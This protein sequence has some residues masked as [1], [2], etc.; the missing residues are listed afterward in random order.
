MNPQPGIHGILFLFF[1]K[2]VS[3]EERFLRASS[4]SSEHPGTRE[5][6]AAP[7]SAARRSGT[8]QTDTRG[9]QTASAPAQTPAAFQLLLFHLLYHSVLELYH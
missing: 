8:G 5:G 1:F 3:L 7:P 2:M 6:F 4:G 9:C